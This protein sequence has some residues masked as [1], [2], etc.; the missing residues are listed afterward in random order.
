M[1][2]IISN[3]TRSNRHLRFLRGIVSV[4]ALL[5]TQGT[6]AAVTEI[7]DIFPVL[8]EYQSI[9][10]STRLGI[11]PAKLT[12]SHDAVVT[13][14]F[15]SEGA[16]Y[17]NTFGWYNAAEDPTDYDNRNLIWANA[18]G[19][20]DGLAGGGD[21]DVGSS[22]TLGKLP[23]G[24]Q[25]GFYLSANGYYTQQA[26]DAA[27]SETVQQVYED[28]LTQ[29]TYYTNDALNPDGISHVVA[30]LLPDRGLL[31]IGWEDLYGGGDRD[32]NDLIVAIDI[33][34]DN[35]KEIAAGAPE[36]AEWALLFAGSITLLAASRSRRRKVQREDAV[37]D[38]D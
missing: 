35:A 10:D 12:L 3:Q 33:G 16:G 14:Y 32:Y 38:S 27:T 23:A 2:T 18:S 30:G 17:K 8:A 9:P 26:L 36:P 28:R 37:Q 15:I 25:L 34:V 1:N 11:D 19:T 7:S 22:F 5:A 20:G 6:M 29:R 31:A 21:L 13:V 24:T 4:F